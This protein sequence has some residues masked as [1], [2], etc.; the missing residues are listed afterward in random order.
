MPPVTL[1]S[2]VL[3]RDVG[4][5]YTGPEEDWLVAQGYARLDSPTGDEPGVSNTGPAD[6]TP[7]KDLTLAENREPRPDFKDYGPLDPAMLLPGD[8]GY[9]ESSA[10]RYDYDAGGVNNDAPTIEGV[11]P[12]EG[13]A[14]TV[15]TVTGYDL[16]GTTEVAFGGVA[17]EELEVVNDHAVRAVVPDGVA[18]GV[19]DVEVTNA[20]GSDVAE[21]AFTVTEPD[22]EPEPEA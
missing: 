1:T 14:G 10:P 16:T 2:Q 18:A 9:G 8:E 7:D 21:D 20:T 5:T 11:E 17:G 6:V 12:D 3:G 13:T 4:D 22:P 15:V 19:V